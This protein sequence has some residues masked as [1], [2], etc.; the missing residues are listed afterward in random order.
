MNFEIMRTAPKITA[1]V[2]GFQKYNSSSD[3]EEHG[4]S[5]NKKI[6]DNNVSPP[7]ISIVSS[8]VSPFAKSKLYQ[9]N[10]TF[11]ETGKQTECQKPIP[12][13][14]PTSQETFLPNDENY[15][16]NEHNNKDVRLS[17]PKMNI[18]LTMNSSNKSP[19]APSDEATFQ[20]I[21]ELEQAKTTPFSANNHQLNGKLSLQFRR[22]SETPRRS[23]SKASLSPQAMKR[24]FQFKRSSSW[25]HKKI[26][27]VSQEIKQMESNT[28]KGSLVKASSFDQSTTRKGTSKTH[29]LV[30]SLETAEEDSVTKI[31][32]DECEDIIPM[33]SKNIETDVLIPRNSHEYD[34]PSNTALPILEVS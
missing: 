15:I 3:S 22:L 7:Q 27:S 26:L 13:I 11:K 32:V 18:N 25:G 2:D 29:V 16:D 6:D 21:P 28:R 12:E 8:K 14:H 24:A 33:I 17:E 19:E 5:K 23:I 1:I 34:S 31:S 10:I 30:S 9:R 4:K 20:T